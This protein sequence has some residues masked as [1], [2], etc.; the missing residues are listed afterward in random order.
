MFIP[1]QASNCIH[2]QALMVTKFWLQL[3]RAFLVTAD[4]SKLLG[5]IAFITEN[6]ISRMFR[7][8]VAH[9]TFCN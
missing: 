4:K 6:R 5:M 3:K 2:N 1:D 8:F 9:I 7:S